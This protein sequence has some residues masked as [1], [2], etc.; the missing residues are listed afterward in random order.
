MGNVMQLARAA[1]GVALTVSCAWLH[2]Q[3]TTRSPETDDFVDPTVY[4]RLLDAIFPRDL[5]NS[6]HAGLM[7]L[8]RSDSSP[9][10]QVV[11]RILSDGSVDARS[12]RVRNGNAYAIAKRYKRQTA[13]EDIQSMAT[14]VEV[15]ERRMAVSRAEVDKW[16]STLLEALEGSATALKRAVELE[17][18]DG[19]ETVI[20]DG[21]VYELWYEYGSV[22]THWSIV[23]TNPENTNQQPLLPLIRWMN[24]VMQRG[25]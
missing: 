1:I 17:R 10:S 18:N 3:Q 23:D 24:M 6:H 22:S 4:S 12:Y 13:S 11:V 5:P 25:G 16:H 19:T 7:I 21:T 8:R 9:E 20:L 2:A 15:E 14:K